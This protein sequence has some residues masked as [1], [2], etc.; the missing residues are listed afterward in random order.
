M[1][2]L[3]NI[4]C[5]ILLGAYNVTVSKERKNPRLDYWRKVWK[6]RKPATLDLW[7]PKRA[8]PPVLIA[9]GHALV[10]ACAQITRALLIATG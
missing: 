10:R 9:L 5:W 6:D 7:K 8:L 2:G 1:L 3:I 4:Y